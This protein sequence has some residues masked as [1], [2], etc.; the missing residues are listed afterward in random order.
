VARTGNKE[1]HTGFGWEYLSER[2]QLEELGVDWR[3]ILKWILK[4]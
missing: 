2:E 3:V 4:K 1:M